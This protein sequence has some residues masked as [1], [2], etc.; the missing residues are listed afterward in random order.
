M[1][2]MLAYCGLAC[3]TCPIRLATLEPD[4]V[5]RAAR[6]EDIARILS[7]IYG[8]PSKAEDITDCDGCR[9][10]GRLLKG[11]RECPIRPCAMVRG[12]ESCAF[13]PDYPCARL[14]AH[15]EHDPE[16]RAR[17]EALRPAV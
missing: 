7:E 3:E 5:A 16:S 17:L 13:C 15:W 11:C 12:V 8:M 10:G 4:E 1:D 2:V 9:A 6:R 14:E